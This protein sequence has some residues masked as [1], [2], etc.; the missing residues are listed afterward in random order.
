MFCRKCGKEI[1]DDSEFCF[2]C[3][4]RVEI[5]VKQSVSNTRNPID[6]KNTNPSLPRPIST[7]KTSAT[8]DKKSDESSLVFDDKEGCMKCTKCGSK[9]LSSSIT[10]CPYCVNETSLIKSDISTN[11]ISAEAL[12]ETQIHQ[13]VKGKSGDSI[14]TTGSDKE[15]TRIRKKPSLWNLGVITSFVAILFIILGIWICTGTDR[16]FYHYPDFIYHMYGE[17]SWGIL[18]QILGI[19]VISIF[20]TICIVIQLYNRNLKNSIIVICL[21]DIPYT[22]SVIRRIRNTYAELKPKLTKRNKHN[23]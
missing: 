16:G 12:N 21:A 4:A 11:N 5:P 10:Y 18:L 19:S 17:Y 14:E 15:K 1:L 22:I 20:V 7:L 2:E 23:R 3:G 9:V 13:K 8:N 6:T